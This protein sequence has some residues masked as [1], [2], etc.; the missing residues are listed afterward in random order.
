MPKSKI[1]II[2]T[3]GTIDSYYE[4]SVDTVIPKEHSVIP[5][6]LKSL[7]LYT[8]FTFSEIC[9]KDSRDLTSQDREK[10][11]QAVKNSKSKRIIIT[12]GTYTIPKTA[13]FISQNLK[14]KNKVIIITGGMIPLEGFAPSDAPFNLGFSIAESQHLPD[15]V[16]V[17]MNGKI[18]RPE[19]VY[20]PQK[21]VQFIKEGRFTSLAIKR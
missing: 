18:F 21:S 9:M 16:Y 11:Y 7:K 19:E 8:D 3:G 4:G 6:Y 10:I 2:L 5:Q 15:G 20:I 13:K 12:H 1:H 17:C 14:I